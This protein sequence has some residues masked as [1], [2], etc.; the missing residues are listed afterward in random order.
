MK[1]LDQASTYLEELLFG[2]AIDSCQPVSAQAREYHYA[3]AYVLSWK[4]ILN[5]FG[6]APSEVV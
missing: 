6:S 5:F 1:V 3:V 2:V 4:L